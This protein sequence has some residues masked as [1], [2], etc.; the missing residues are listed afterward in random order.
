[1]LHVT[2]NYASSD[3]T[4]VSDA[5]RELQRRLPEGWRV[6]E[7]RVQTRRFD[8]TVELKAPDGTAGRIVLEA[9]EHLDPRGVLAVAAL[10]EEVSKRGPLVVISPYLSPSTRE[11]LRKHGIG[12]LDLTGNA[13]IVTAKPSLFIETQGSMAD[14]GRKKRP[15]RSLK[16][17]KAGR[18]VRA[19]VDR[20]RPPGVREIAATTGVDAGYVSRVVAL[21]Y[22]EQLVTRAGHGR[23]QSVDW[24][25]LLRRWASEAP[26]ESRG[27]I[28]TYLEARGL[29]AF[30]ERLGKY[31][32][33]YAVTG[34]LA[35]ARLAPLAPARLAAVWM[36]SPADAADRLGLRAAESGANVLLVKPNDDLVF[37]GAQEAGG[38]WYTAP[39][40]T[41]ADLLTS[42][43]RGPAEGEALLEWMRDN[44]EAWRG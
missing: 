23:I 9:K 30:L 29:P 32:E 14:P 19:L 13:R 24:L 42:P 12:Y 44:E 25:G 38:L 35:A 5:L 22:S 41:V 15:A 7:A 16:G 34:G 10:A 18:V 21:L 2:R 40:Q 26:L 28:H 36:R 43:G 1:M 17:A 27:E 3:N 6:G 37:Q 8:A 33:R 4:G 31:Q 20:R 39:S 11:S